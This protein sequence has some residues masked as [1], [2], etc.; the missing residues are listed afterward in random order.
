MTYFMYVPIEDFPNI[1]EQLFIFKRFA[2]IEQKI[3]HT[4]QTLVKETQSLSEEAKEKN[5]IENMIAETEKMQNLT[6]P[7]RK[8]MM[9]ALTCAST[10]MKCKKRRQP[11]DEGQTLV[12]QCSEAQQSPQKKRRVSCG[13]VGLPEVVDQQSTGKK[14]PK[15]KVNILST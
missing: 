11:P 13:E 10:F 8:Q 7:I 4:F 9:K 1:L 12:A 14:S 3:L 5:K 2:T 15:A 6:N